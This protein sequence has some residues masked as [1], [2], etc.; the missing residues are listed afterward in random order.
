MLLD[1]IYGLDKGHINEGGRWSKHWLHIV[2]LHSYRGIVICFVPDFLV[3]LLS[4]GV[5]ETS[6]GASGL[7]GNYWNA[8]QCRYFLNIFQRHIFGFSI[9]QNYLQD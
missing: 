7:V 1:K 6:I 5:T 8:Q 2:I 9:L 3:P 4:N